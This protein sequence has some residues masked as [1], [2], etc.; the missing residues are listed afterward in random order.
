MCLLLGLALPTEP[1]KYEEDEW[2]R[3]TYS[4]PFLVSA[5]LITLLLV[6][7]KYESIDFSIKHS[8]DD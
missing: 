1:E 8:R 7:Y 2:W 3:L 4:F 5:I 6:K